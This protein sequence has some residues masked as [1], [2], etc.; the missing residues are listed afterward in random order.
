MTLFRFFKVVVFSLFLGS[1][2]SCAVAIVHTRLTPE[3]TGV[4]PKIVPYVNEYLELAAIQGIK[5]RHSVT[6]G[7]KDIQEDYVVG[8]T[9]YGLF[10]FREIDIDA[11]FWRESTWI[12]RLTLVLH[13]LDHAYCYRKHDYGDGKDYDEEN[14]KHPIVGEGYFKDRCPVSIMFPVI[15]PDDCMI[16]HYGEYVTELFDRCEPF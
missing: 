10:G 2:L 6:I 1:L 8:I 12:S 9:N 4:D 13:E 7:F 14:I 11:T 3:Y 16:R 5:F 15:L